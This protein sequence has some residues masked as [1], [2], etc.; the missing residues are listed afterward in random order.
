MDFSVF[1]SQN[2]LFHGIKSS[3]IPTLLEE[4][5][6]I[7]IHLGKGQEL[8]RR[9][10]PVSNVYIL[11]SGRAN[12]VRVDYSGNAFIYARLEPGSIFGDML[13]AGKE[14]KS[15]VT[16]ET[17]TQAQ[18]LS[19]PFQNLLTSPHS[20]RENH[21]LLLQNLISM[22]SE[23]YFALLERVGCLSAPTLRKKIMRYLLGESRLQNRDIFR[24]PFDR[25]GLAAYLGADR[26][27]LSRELSKMKRDGLIDYEKNSFKILKTEF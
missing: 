22:Y 11:L 17:L 24:I 1:L 12:A 2:I 4:L 20:N 18:V 23:K 10:D 7:Q 19:I 27:A 8:I 16:I 15:L 3:D 26:S 13:A 6:A 14:K 9:G 5:S 25:A 21:L